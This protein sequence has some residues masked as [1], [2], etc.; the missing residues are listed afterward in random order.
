MKSRSRKPSTGSAPLTRALEDW[1]DIRVFL[2]IHRTGSLSAA[3]STMKITQPTCGRRLSALE[4]ALG[5]QLFTRTP[6]GL[7]LTAEGNALLAAA[8][9]MEDAARSV[10]LRAAASVAKLDGVVRIAMTEFTALAFG[11]R[12]LPAIRERYAGIRIELVL[13]DTFADILSRE[14]DLAIRWRGEGFRPSPA[15]VL[16]RKL[17]RIDWCLFGAESY[18]VR[19]GTPRDPNNLNGHDVV[20]YEGGVHPGSEWLTKAARDASVALVSA[21]MLCNAAAVSEGL[22]LGFFPKPIVRIQPTL[23]ALTQPI[24]WA[25][26][27]LVMHPDLR[28]V[29]RIRAVAD[30]L[31]ASLRDDLASF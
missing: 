17:G 30:M 26:A 21:N 16:A 15:K 11:A 31:A 19:R 18:F 10:A 6:A 9:Q 5:T 8:S 24:G 23:R 13:A 20:L 28:R 22:G 27:W 4:E 25:W 1:D 12:V 2:A 3:A 7:Q 14:A 29:P